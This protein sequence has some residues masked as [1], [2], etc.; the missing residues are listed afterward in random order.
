MLFL[1]TEGSKNI[2]PE[3]GDGGVGEN[4]YDFEL[5]KRQCDEAKWPIT[6]CGAGKY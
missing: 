5:P 6:L 4:T 3:L 2:V 1:L